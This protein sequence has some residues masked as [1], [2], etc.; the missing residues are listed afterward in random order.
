MD[1]RERERMKGGE[2]K[3]GEKERVR[4]ALPPP[5]ARLLVALPAAAAAAAGPADQ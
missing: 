1:G 3:R 5:G 2:R 4:E